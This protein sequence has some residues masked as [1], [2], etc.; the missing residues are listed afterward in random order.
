MLYIITESGDEHKA[1]GIGENVIFPIENTMCY[2]TGEEV[3]R[4]IWCPII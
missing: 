2:C 3:R 1:D 4:T